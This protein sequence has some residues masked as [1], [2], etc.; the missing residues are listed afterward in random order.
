MHFVIRFATQLAETPSSRLSGSPRLKRLDEIFDKEPHVARLLLVEGVDGEEGVGV[1][2]PVG[3]QSD[4]GAIR[5]VVRHEF[6][7]YQDHPE[8]LHRRLFQGDAVV[9]AEAG[10]GQ[11]HRHALRVPGEEPLVGGGG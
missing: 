4:Q 5:Q 8:P 6:I 9:G 2:L 1:G 11:L 7:R 10:G 3:E